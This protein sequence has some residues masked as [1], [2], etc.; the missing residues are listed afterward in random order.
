LIKITKSV[1][2]L[3]V[4]WRRAACY[5]QQVALTGVHAG[6]KVAGRGGALRSLY[7]S[8]LKRKT[9]GTKS[10][11]STGVPASCTLD[12][13]MQLRGESHFGPTGVKQQGL[14]QN[15]RQDGNPDLEAQHLTGKQ[16]KKNTWCTAIISACGRHEGIES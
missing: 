7:V 6:G 13:R 16:C 14:Q 9:R 5:R 2:R 11:K 3:K 12:V 4:N 15:G 10:N 1:N 8:K